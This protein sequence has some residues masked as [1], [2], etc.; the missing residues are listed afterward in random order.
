MRWTF[1]QMGQKSQRDDKTFCVWSFWSFSDGQLLLGPFKHDNWLVAVKFSPDG[2]RIATASWECDSVRVYDGSNVLADFPIRVTSD[3][4]ETLAWAS[5]SNRLFALSKDGHIHCLDVSTKNTLAKWRIHSGDEPNCIALACN[6]RVIAASANSSLSLWD[7]T[8]HQQIGTVIYH[9]HD[10][11]SMAISPSCV[12]ATAGNKAITLRHLHDILP[13][14]YRDNVSNAARVRSRPYQFIL[15]CTRS[16]WSKK[17][18][19]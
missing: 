3:L 13:S 6:D 19:A 10:I 1:Q 5:D 8:T 4:N 7:N 2:R 16:A 17:S 15:G 12:I 18:G 11:Y 14:P 9:S